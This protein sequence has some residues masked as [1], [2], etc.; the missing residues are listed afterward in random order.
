MS[1]SPDGTEQAPGGRTRAPWRLTSAGLYDRYARALVPGWLQWLLG[2]AVLA[3]VAAVA[4]LAIRPHVTSDAERL[5]ALS[6]PFVA[7]IVI[8]V[9][10]AAVEDG[11]E[12]S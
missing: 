7:V 9:V 10:R 8:F 12:E 11:D 4:W 6:L 1:S 2:V 5:F 3:C